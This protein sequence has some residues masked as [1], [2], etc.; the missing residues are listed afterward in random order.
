MACSG[1]PAK[2]GKLDLQVAFLGARSGPED[3]EDESGAID[4]LAIP[5]PFQVALLNGC[6]R[7]VDHGVRRALER[8]R[9]AIWVGRRRKVDRERNGEIEGRA[10]HRGGASKNSLTRWYTTWGG[11]DRGRR[12]EGGLFSARDIIARKGPLDE[13]D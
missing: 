3:L 9:W 6:E 12:Y 5:G 13:L 4:H 11:S 7:G 8:A 2:G 10:R 1:P